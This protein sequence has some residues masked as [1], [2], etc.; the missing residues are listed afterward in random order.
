MPRVTAF[1]SSSDATVSAAD[2]VRGF[3][4]RLP[5]PGNELVRSTSIAATSGSPHRARTAQRVRA[6]ARR[7]RMPPTDSRDQRLAGVPAGGGGRARGRQHRGWAEP[8]GLE[9][10]PASFGGPRRP[11]VHDRRPGLWPEPKQ[12]GRSLDD[13]DLAVRGESGAIVV[14]LRM[15]ARLRSNPFF[16]VVRRGS[17][18]R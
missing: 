4:L 12:T 17:A 9:W 15:F 2:V 13:R 6:A 18:P 16:E 14:P 7:A 5:G 8:L 10:R 11:A 1:Q 3:M